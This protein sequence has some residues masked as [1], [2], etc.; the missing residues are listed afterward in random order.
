MSENEEI[1]KM[2]MTFLDDG[3]SLRFTFENAF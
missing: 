3:L 1:R 2:K